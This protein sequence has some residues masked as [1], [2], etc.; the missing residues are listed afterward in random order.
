MSLAMGASEPAAPSSSDQVP[1]VPPAKRSWRESLTPERKRLFRNFL[2]ATT[3][4]YFSVMITKRAALSRRHVPS[5]FHHN[6]YV[7]TFNKYQDGI[8]AVTLGTLLSCSTFAMG[9]TGVALAFNINNAQ[10]F[11]AAMRKYM[12]GLG[13]QTELS[14]QLEKNLDPKTKELEDAIEN[15]L[16]DSFPNEKP[17]VK[18]KKND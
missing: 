7:P 10:E 11:H 6:N 12:R 5:L 9:V 17:D 8:Q 15:F 14:K 4:T 18:E 13:L 2:F 16:S 3:A 1:P